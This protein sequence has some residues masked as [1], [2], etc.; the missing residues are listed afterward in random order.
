MR[1]VF[2]ETN[3][4]RNERISSFWVFL[5]LPEEH[6]LLQF[7]SSHAHIW[8]PSASFI[9]VDAHQAAGDSWDGSSELLDSFLFCFVFCAVSNPQVKMSNCKAKINIFTD[10]YYHSLIAK[11]YFCDI[12]TGG[13]NFCRLHHLKLYKATDL[14]IIKSV[15]FWELRC[16]IIRAHYVEQCGL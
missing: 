8:A 6:G 9:V 15:C 5:F 4:N 3:L 7:N 12:C 16:S 11:L 10:Q 1:F 2:A 13:V 14:C